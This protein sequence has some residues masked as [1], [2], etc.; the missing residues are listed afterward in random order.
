ML[1]GGLSSEPPHK[2][3]LAL[4][5]TEV[6]REGGIE[7]I[8]RPWKAS[9]PLSPMKDSQGARGC[10]Q[11]GLCLAQW[12][13]KPCRSSVTGHADAVRSLCCCP[14]HP[15]VTTGFICLGLWSAVGSPPSS[16]LLAHTF[17]LS[18]TRRR[19]GELALMTVIQKQYKKWVNL[20]PGRPQSQDSDGFFLTV[21]LPNIKQKLQ[22]EVKL[23]IEFLT[24]LSSVIWRREEPSS[25]H[26]ASASVF[27][28]VAL[29]QSPSPT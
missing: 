14:G 24:C 27:R 21:L 26:P 18:H 29:T 3:S 4:Q 6:P 9:A 10:W 8:V 7:H 2:L 17:D 22:A 19:P 13:Q 12:P 20:R 28:P 15:R 5:E 11:Q 25:P 1:A 16:L 23:K